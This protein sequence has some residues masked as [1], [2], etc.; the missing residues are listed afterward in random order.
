MTSD[1]AL[2]PPPA[3]AGVVLVVD[4]EPRNRT[5]LRDL[6]ESHGYSVEEAAN[7]LEGL[8]LA[9][10]CRP[11][12]IL[13][14]VMM[15][16]LDG[17]EVC[18]QLKAARE[19]M[20]VPVLMVTSLSDRVER[21]QG[22]RAGANDF[23]T[24]PLDTADLLLRVRNAV[25]GKRLYDQMERQYIRLRELEALRDDLVHMVVHDLR[26]PLAALSAYLQL[27]SMEMGPSEPEGPG[28]LVAEALGLSDQMTEMI[29]TVLDVSRLESG[30]MPLELSSVDLARVAQQTV[31]RL[32]PSLMQRVE[33]TQPPELPL[34][35]CDEVLIGRVI[36]NLV[37]NALKFTANGHLVRV[38]ITPEGPH[39]RV[40]VSD[41]GPGIPEEELGVIF[42]KFGQARGQ[43]SHRNHASGLGLTFCRMTVEAHGGEIGVDSRL[44]SGSTFWFRLPCEPG[45]LAASGSVE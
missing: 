29:S 12:V 28:N 18:R 5:L 6:L 8:Q 17:F 42:E 25:N 45:S 19:T 32:G 23:V 30:K 36:S 1:D 14:D 24:K 4:D 16:R 35:R 44:G 9:S 21:L 13:L 2:F 10:R 37:G 33:V 15:P 11:D 22:I 39:L 26:S 34:A 43:G 3:T 20:P 41:H 38:T 7:G 31:S 40:A 27:L